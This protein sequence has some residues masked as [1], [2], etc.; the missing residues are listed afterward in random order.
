MSHNARWIAIQSGP[1]GKTI[2]NKV[3]EFAILDAVTG[4]VKDHYSFEGISAFR[5]D[6]SRDDDWLAVQLSRNEI[7]IWSVPEFRRQATI[8]AEHRHESS[9]MRFHHRGKV[10]AVV[11]E[12]GEVL[13]FEVTSGKK[14][15]QITAKKGATSI[16]FS[17]TSDLLAIGYSDG[18]VEV[19]NVEVTEPT[20]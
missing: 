15:T 16:S 3:G 13:L 18:T 14:L 10:C 8:R 17:N 1:S 11:T 5:F 6:F 9:V 12:Q 4:K 7:G 2:H 20:K 19:W